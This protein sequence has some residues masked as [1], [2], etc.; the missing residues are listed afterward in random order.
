MSEPI[1]GAA[2][3]AASWKLIGGLAGMGAIAA[4]LA[5]F[6]VMSMTRPKDEKEWRV[7]LACTLV[8]SIGGGAAMAR[9]L[10]IQHWAHDPIGL[11][12]L[13]CVAF[14]CGLPAWGIVRALFKYL[15]KKK[16]A[17][18]AEIIQDVKEVV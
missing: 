1:S 9:Y 6:V 3:G 12:G 11:V 16:D 15:D 5:A 17:D 13:L 7:A 8:G 4:G 18:L 14:T 10:G 2:A